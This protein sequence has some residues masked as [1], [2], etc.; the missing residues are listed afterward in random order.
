MSHLQTV[1]VQVRETNNKEEFTPRAVGLFYKP[2]DRSVK[3]RS[4]AL[5]EKEVFI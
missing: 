2:S 4:Q 1:R 5:L 3:C